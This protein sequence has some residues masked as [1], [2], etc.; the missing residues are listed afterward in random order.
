MRIILLGAPGAGKG[1]QAEKLVAKLG[2]PQIS[3]G[4]ILRKAQQEQTELGKQA[5]QYMKEGALVPDEIVVGIVQERL[6][7]RDCQRGYILDGFPRSASQAEALDVT[8]QE[9]QDQLTAV[10]SLK[11]PE[12]ELVR[13]LLSRR[14]EDDNKDVIQERLAIYTQQTKP[15][16][17]YYRSHRLLDEVDGQGSVDEIFDRIM[18]TLQRRQT[19][20]QAQV[21]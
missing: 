8:L 5:G 11:V 14:R 4:E 1:T 13:R 6:K 3:T 2:V 16:I 20:S 12:D 18:S 19:A 21:G 15:L 10:I 17:D 7:Q 9:M